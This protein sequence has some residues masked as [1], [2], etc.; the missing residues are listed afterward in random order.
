MARRWASTLLLVYLMAEATVIAFLQ[1]PPTVCMMRIR[2]GQGTLR[3]CG[4]SASY[5]ADELHAVL[6]TAKEAARAAGQVM[7]ENLGASLTKTKCSNKDL[8][9][10][11]DPMCQVVH[12]FSRARYFGTRLHVLD[13]PCRVLLA[14]APVRV[15]RAVLQGRWMRNL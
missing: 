12:T 9:T 6:Q 4:P 2:G 15:C 8:L 1:A 10:E 7:Q 5:T 11:I 13:F 3:M 14:K